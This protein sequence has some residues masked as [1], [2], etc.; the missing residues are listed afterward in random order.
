MLKVMTI[1]GTRPELIRLSRVI[2]RL[3]ETVEHVLV[4]TGQNYDYN[5]NGVFFRDLGIREPDHL[6]G[7]DT[8]S[9]GRVLGETLIRTEEVLVAERPD[10]VLILGDTNSSISAVMAKRMRIPV[11][12]WKRVT[13][14]ST[15]GS[16]RRPIGAWWTMSPTSTWCTPSMRAAT[17]WP[18]ACI[19]AASC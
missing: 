10:A 5:L 11:I 7:V 12:T 16:R 18:R 1:V 13:D 15:K 6:L 8:S 2:A 4:H 3:D 14:A 17:Y 19:R 9:L